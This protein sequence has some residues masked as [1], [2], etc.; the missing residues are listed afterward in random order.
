MIH[1]GVLV[2]LQL[3]ELFLPYVHHICSRDLCAVVLVSKVDA[4]QGIWSG[5]D[6][7][8]EPSA[9][10]VRYLS[11]VVQRVAPSRARESWNDNR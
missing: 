5:D 2:L 9:T 10:V 4:V 7:R 1:A 3:R 11:N 6:Q 8:N